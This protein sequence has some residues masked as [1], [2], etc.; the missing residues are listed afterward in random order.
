MYDEYTGELIEDPRFHEW[1]EQLQKELSKMS[2]TVDSA[3]HKIKTGCKDD[4]Y[5]YSDYNYDNYVPD[6]P[7]YDVNYLNQFGIQILTARFG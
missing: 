1:S 2:Q 5:G 3:A 7:Q 4:E 6:H